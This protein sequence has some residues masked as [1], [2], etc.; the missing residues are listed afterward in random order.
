MRL[1]VTVVA[2]ES[3]SVAR[4]TKRAVAALADVVVPTTALG[5]LTATET[6]APEP[7]LYASGSFEERRNIDRMKLVT[8]CNAGSCCPV[9]KI[10]DTQ[11]EIGEEGNLCVLTPEQWEALREKIL[12]G[13][14]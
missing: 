11:V 10:K 14:A 4:S 5:H 7:F 6:V 3:Q 8:L 1:E 2:L 13:E 9:V 12:K